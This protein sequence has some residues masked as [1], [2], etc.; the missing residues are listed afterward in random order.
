[1][2]CLSF[3]YEFFFRV[4]PIEKIAEI[5][6]VKLKLDTFLSEQTFACSLS[7]SLCQ[8]TTKTE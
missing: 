8:I 3:N 4:H 6:Y 7:L 5:R 1:M 2:K